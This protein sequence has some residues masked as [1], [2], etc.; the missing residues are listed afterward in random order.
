MIQSEHYQGADGQYYSVF[1]LNE[2]DTSPIYRGP[3]NLL[4]DDCRAGCAHS[5]DAHNATVEFQNKRRD[6]R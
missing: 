1:R 4:C 2:N 3:Y 6:G 5:E